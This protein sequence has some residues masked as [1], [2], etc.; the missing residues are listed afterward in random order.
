MNYV[1]LGCIAQFDDFFASAYNYLNPIYIEQG[2]KIENFRKRKLC[3]TDETYLEID[4]R[5]K[6]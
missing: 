4:E 1:A 3:I 6:N 2:Y 5:L